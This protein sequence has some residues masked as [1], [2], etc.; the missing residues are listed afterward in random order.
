MQQ[1]VTTSTA[2][3]KTVI[4]GGRCIG[5]TLN[6]AGVLVVELSD[7]VTADGQHLSPAKN[8]GVKIGDLIQSF[9][10]HSIST[11][12]ELTS[13][14]SASGGKSCALQI[15]RDGKT[16]ELL[17][18]PKASNA[19]GSFKIG[20]WVKDAASGIGTLTFYDPET[21]KFAALGHGICDPETGKIIP[22]HDGSILSSTIVSIDKGEKG[23]PGELNGIFKENSP[24]LGTISQNSETGIHGTATAELFDGGTPIPIADRKSVTPGKAEIFANIEGSAV[25][26]FDA[27]IIKIIPK[28]ISNQKDFIIRITD[29]KLINKT[30]GIVQGMSGSPII[31]NGKL[32]GAVTHVFVNDPTRGY[33][34]FIENMLAE[35]EKN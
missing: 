26:K 1:S 16:T 21:K 25:E 20:A 10:N 12:A 34:I 18:E 11:V 14:I 29:A 28:T 13:A 23:F 5:V 3:S 2:P 31:Q 33:G 17:V 4:P 9:D 27:E 15:N 24:L 35:A 22:I 19:D 6:T 8:A 32:V 30:G 7:I